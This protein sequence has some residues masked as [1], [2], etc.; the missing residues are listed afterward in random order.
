MNTPLP[1]HAAPSDEALLAAFRGGDEAAFSSLFLR[2]RDR[3]VGYATRMLGRREEGEEVCVEAFCKVV[4]GTW[5]SGGSFRGF[6]FTVTHRRCLDRLRRRGTARRRQQR[7]EGPAR[8]AV[9]PEARMIEG[10]RRRR[11]EA[12]LSDLGHQHRAAVLLYY[13]EGLPSKEVARVMGVSDQ[14]VRSLLSYARRKLR[15]LLAEVDL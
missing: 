10:A 6:L 9:D 13:G 4:E 12:A 15:G 8:A 1:V 11:L 5:R 7:V 14:Q 2:H 3:V